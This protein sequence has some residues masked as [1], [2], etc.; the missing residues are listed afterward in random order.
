V[1]DD[2]LHDL[3]RDLSRSLIVSVAPEEVR[4]FGP[5]SAAYYRD[6]AAA[7]RARKERDEVLG[8]GVEA[9]AVIATPIVLS[10]VTD[11]VR[12]LTQRLVADAGEHGAQVAERG[13]QALLQRARS[14]EAVPSVPGLTEAQL[15]EVRER[16][17]EK[18]RE[19]RLS[20]ARSALLAD[21]L[22]GSLSASSTA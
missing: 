21:A 11:V 22:V 15:R 10:V 16:A 17:Y 5:L 13:V 8:F 3:I 7:T 1:A 19:L 9:A 2:T 20:D 14:P 4:L 6:P 18:A 12:H